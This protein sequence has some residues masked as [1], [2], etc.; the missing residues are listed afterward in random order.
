MMSQIGLPQGLLYGE[1]DLNR[2][3]LQKKISTFVKG[4]VKKYRSWF[5]EPIGQQHYTR[6]ALTC[7]AQD[8]KWKEALE[9]F[10]IIADVEE[11]RLEDL[12]NQLRVLMLLEN[13][14]GPFKDEARADFLDMQDL[15]DLIDPEKGPEDVP[16]M[17]TGRSSF[18]VTD[19][20][21]KSFGVE[22]GN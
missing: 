18:R 1:Q 17:P 11:F 20:D 6:I 13:L 14:V 22:P 3:T 9:H 7:A 16:P 5:L 21:G 15:P 2:D 10:E 8:D 19:G 12:E 4:P